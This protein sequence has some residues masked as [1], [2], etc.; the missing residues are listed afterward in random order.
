M[1]Y[2]DL[3]C[4]LT[5]LQQNKVPRPVDHLLQGTCGEDRG[6]NGECSEDV[7]ELLLN[8][9]PFLA[10]GRESFDCWNPGDKV[11]SSQVDGHDLSQALEVRSSSA[12][13]N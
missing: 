6:D 8:S 13:A 4:N 1:L 2:S 10:H 5:E 3:V 9:S 11:P 7:I 12:H